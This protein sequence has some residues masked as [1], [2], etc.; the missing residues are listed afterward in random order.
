M[1]RPQ[2]YAVETEIATGLTWSERDTF[3]CSH[4]SKIIHVKP[5]CDPADLGGHC[6]L[7]D[8]LICPKCA[9]LMSLGKPCIPWLEKV[10]RVANM[11]ERGLPYID[12]MELP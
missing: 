1:K 2:G 5:M 12:P 8:K 3:T 10:Q 7:C 4:C 11:V 6:K 9:Y